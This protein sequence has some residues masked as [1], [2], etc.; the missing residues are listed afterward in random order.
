MQAASIILIQ[1]MN[2]NDNKNYRAK[3]LL[4]CIQLNYFEHKQMNIFFVLRQIEAMFENYR[5]E[6][7]EEGMVRN[8]QE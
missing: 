7:W 8:G 3:N 2:N 1:L 6:K 4:H 5:D